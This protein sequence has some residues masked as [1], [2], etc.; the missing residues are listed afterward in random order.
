MSELRTFILTNEDF[1]EVSE[2]IISVNNTKYNV[3]GLD[4][5]DR[6]KVLAKVKELMGYDDSV[7]VIGEFYQ[8]CISNYEVKVIPLNKTSS[9]AFV[10]ISENKTLTYDISVPFSN[11]EGVLNEV[12]KK[13]NKEPVG[14]DYSNM[15]KRERKLMLAGEFIGAFIDTS[16][17]LGYTI[18]RCQEAL[19]KN[20]EDKEAK[21]TLDNALKTKENIKNYGTL[22]DDPIYKDLFKKY[23]IDRYYE[24]LIRLLEE[25]N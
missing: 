16:A 10:V 19:N 24:T 5:K 2:G 20:P 7:K 25:V 21:S 14:V 6:T 22:K 9:R 13:I 8:G 11:I 18:A 3:A 15:T 4:V 12:E 23:G 17:R 1:V